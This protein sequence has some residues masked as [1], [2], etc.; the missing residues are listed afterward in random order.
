MTTLKIVNTKMRR[1]WT[2]IEK[3]IWFFTQ[4]NRFPLIKVINE[5]HKNNKPYNPDYLVKKAV[6]NTQNEYS[7][8]FCVC[9]L[10]TNIFCK[11]E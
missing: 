3:S 8:A 6:L 2:E 11:I 9:H 4:L 1:D 5:R 10:L 7:T